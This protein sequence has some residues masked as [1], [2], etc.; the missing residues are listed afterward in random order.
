VFYSPAVFTPQRGRATALAYLHAAE[1][2]FSAT[3]CHYVEKWYG[4]D[5]AV[6][7][8]AA[9]RD[10][11]PAHRD[12]VP[13]GGDAQEHMDA[14]AA[15]GLWI[16]D[17]AEFVEHAKKNPGALAHG[18]PGNGS[19]PHLAVELFQLQSGV[20]TLH[21]PY[22]GGGPAVIDLVAGQVSFMIG[23]PLEVMQQVKAGKLAVL[24]V[25]SSQRLSY[26]PD[27]ATFKESGAGDY[28]AYAWFGVVVRAG[29][30]KDM[31]ERLNADIV[32]VLRSPEVSQR[33]TAMGTDVAA[34]STQDFARFL[35]AEH[36]RWSAAVK[37]AK[38]T[39][40]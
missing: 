20:Q 7:H 37:A 24:G 39:M 11:R 27:V 33:L 31:V 3:N 19:L 12:E 32:S 25:T 29:T 2:M 1:Q 10:P 4:E 28:E 9:Q 35:E 36:Q 16:A 26:W 40:N 5:S 8:F 14:A 22:K 18:T 13:V 34:G 38:L 17:Q 15:G 23:S 21:V 30:P 6:L